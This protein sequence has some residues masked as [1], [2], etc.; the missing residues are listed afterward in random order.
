MN[1]EHVRVL[2][3]RRMQQAAEAGDA[4][5]GGRSLVTAGPGRGPPPGGESAG[6][7]GRHESESALAS[8]GQAGQSAG[9]AGADLRLV[10]RG[11]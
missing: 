2:V 8:A 9:A 10:H 5:G 11:L 6:A 7:A 4:T 3:A 1:P